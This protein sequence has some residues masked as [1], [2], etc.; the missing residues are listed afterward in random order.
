MKHSVWDKVIFKSYYWIW[1][2]IIDSILI[3]KDNYTYNLWKHFKCK[4]ED[5]LKEISFDK[6]EKVIIDTWLEYNI[7]DHVFFLTE[8]NIISDWYVSWYNRKKS[9]NIL[10]FIEWNNS[11]IKWITKNHKDLYEDIWYEESTL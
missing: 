3:E 2:E 11:S 10:W 8:Y 4:D 9:W 6:E 5:I 7:W 1:Y